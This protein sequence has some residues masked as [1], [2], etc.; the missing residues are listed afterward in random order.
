MSTQTNFLKPLLGATLVCVGLIGTPATFAACDAPQ[1][2]KA[3]VYEDSQSS[4]LMQINIKLN[5]FAPKR[6]KCL[7]EEFKRTY[8]GRKTIGV[9]IFSSY[10]AAKHYRIVTGDGV[11]G[12][13]PDWGREM[14][15][16]YFY[17]V[18]RNI[19]YLEILPFGAH[20]SFGTRID[21]S[22]R[23]IPLCR[24]QIS[25]RC[26]LSAGSPEYP[27][28]AVAVRTSGAITV[29]GNIT[30][31]GNVTAIRV[32]GV[33]P[34]R[35]KDGGLLE[36]AAVSNLKSWHFEP[37]AK[38]QPVRITYV[39]EIG[40]RGSSPLEFNLPDEVIIRSRP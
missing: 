22:S 20:S 23:S 5:D 34:D 21:M 11:G 4:T 24:L 2:R 1:F 27:S 15:A 8:S 19:E 28:N 16:D 29:T 17:D 14:H 38:E 3:V 36:N 9:S 10:N 7:V 32:V 40:P 18:A 39:F 30:A 25:G 31:D 6:L 33:S 26:L 35:R 13:L 12:K 37:A